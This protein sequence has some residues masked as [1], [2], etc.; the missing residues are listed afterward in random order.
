MN[1]DLLKNIGK[2]I[3]AIRKNKGLTQA[4]LAEDLNMTTSAFSKIELGRNNTPIKRLYEIANIL[5]VSPVEFFEDSHKVSEPS[6]KMGFATK[7]DFETLKRMMES[8]A[9]K[10]DDL[11]SKSETEKKYKAL[12]KG[13][14]KRAK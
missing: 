13:N 6:E 14:S 11:S 7:D 9:K 1:K 12:V 8:L 10:V 5:E 4:S 3:R 2:R